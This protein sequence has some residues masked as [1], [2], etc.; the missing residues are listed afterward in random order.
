MLK[1]PSS[2]RKLEEQG[3]GPAIAAP[4][5]ADAVEDADGLASREWPDGSSRL[6]GG[7]LEPW[8][9]AFSLIVVADARQ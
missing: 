2:S 7:C 8:R 4:A 5:E 6:R 9:R 3:G 1:P